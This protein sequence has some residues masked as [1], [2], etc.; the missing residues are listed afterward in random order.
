MKLLLLIFFVIQINIAISG[1]ERGKDL[2]FPDRNLLNS[3]LKNS[4][5]SIDLSKI[6]NINRLLPDGTLYPEN[7]DSSNTSEYDKMY[8]LFGTYNDF[9]YKFLT[10]ELKNEMPDIGLPKA[11]PGTPQ[12]LDPNFIGSLGFLLNSP[13]SFFYYN[14]SKEEISKRKLY[15]IHAYEP[16]RRKINA[17]Y[18]AENIKHWTGLEGEELTQFV[19][20][21]HFDDSYLENVAEYELIDSV[22][23]K[24]KE[25]KAI[26]TNKQ[27]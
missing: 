9:K 11:K 10:L 22:L 14:M 4:I 18:N 16:I 23:I 12:L 15:E 26:T 17:K 13:I 19:L 24:L 6:H 1:Q 7:I 21:C 20:Y 2:L 3:E 27:N 8:R 25:F 5:D